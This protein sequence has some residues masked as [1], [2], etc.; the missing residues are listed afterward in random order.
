MGSSFLTP[1]SAVH[2]ARL[3][4]AIKTPKLPPLPNQYDAILAQEL[5]L[6]HW[7]VTDLDALPCRW[8]Q[9]QLPWVSQ[10]KEGRAFRPVGTLPVSSVPFTGVD[11]VVLEEV[12]PV[13]YDGVITEIVCEIAA[14]TPPGNGFQEGSGMVTWRLAADHRFLRDWGNIQVSSG[15]LRVP[16]AIL[17]K[18]VRVYQHNLLQFTVAFTPAAAGALN[19]AGVVICSIV[20]WYW[21]RIYRE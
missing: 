5:E 3:R 10:P 17:R 18:G 14:P 12:V 13:G 4:P 21:P 20:G 8:P 16:S 15:S 9:D 6:W 7:M 19:P 2:Q 1:Q 11:T